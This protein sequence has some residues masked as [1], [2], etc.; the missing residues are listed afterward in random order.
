VVRS[1]LWVYL[2][3]LEQLDPAKL[4]VEGQRE[5]KVILEDQQGQLAQKVTRED[6]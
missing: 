6:Q 2:D 1:D 5:Q 4:D 3:Q